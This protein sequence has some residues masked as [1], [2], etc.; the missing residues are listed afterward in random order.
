V[1]R[2][3]YLDTYR[4]FLERLRKARQEAG[5]SQVAAAAALGKP[6]SYVSYCETGGR[7]VDVEELREFARLYG[8]PIS[9]FLDD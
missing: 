1:V 7:R 3:I 4:Q 9:Y 5:M 2:S 8:K 6:Q